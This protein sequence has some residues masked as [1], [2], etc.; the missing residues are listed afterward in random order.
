MS[1]KNE[2]YEKWRSDLTST[3]TQKVLDEIHSYLISNPPPGVK[4][5][6]PPKQKKDAAEEPKNDDEG[7]DD[8]N[9]EGDD[10]DADYDDEDDAE[11][12]DEGE[13]ECDDE[14]A[15]Y[16]DEEDY[17]EDSLFSA[18]ENDEVEELKNTWV[19]VTPSR[20]KR[21]RKAPNRLDPSFCK[22]H[23]GCGAVHRDGF[24]PTDMMYSGRP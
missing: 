14:D 12:D 10:S 22:Q 9:D 3:V 13:A 8:C 1:R 23:K 15:D 11:C 16:D 18:S 19:D 2:L 21:K 17:S 20:R 7:D 4:S 5:T 24:D 6:P